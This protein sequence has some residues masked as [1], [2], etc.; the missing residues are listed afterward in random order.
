V[1]NAL[2][3]LGVTDSCFRITVREQGSVADEC[4]DRYI[5][6]KHFVGSRE[7]IL[8]AYLSLEQMTACIVSYNMLI[9]VSDFAEPTLCGC[10]VAVAFDRLL[11]ERAQAF[12]M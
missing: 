6:L 8:T 9:V 11:Q 10:E 2:E 4:I 5:D 7:Q 12:G 1:P 3:Q